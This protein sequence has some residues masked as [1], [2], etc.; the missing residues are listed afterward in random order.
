[1]KR[2]IGLLISFSS[3][4]TLSAQDFHYSMFTMA[5]LALNP[6]LTGNY[7]GD[8][9][10]VNNYRMQ[11]GSVATKPYSTYSFGGDMPIKKN[12]K[13]KASPDFFAVGLNVNMDKAGS[14]SLKNNQFA[15]MGSYNKS[16]D[17]TGETFFSLG[18]Q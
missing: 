10:I 18:F 8:L 9:R 15:A 16:L 14:T 11:W 4:A 6:A 1:M 3:L 13:R 7:T 17:G 12:D 5:P 2:I